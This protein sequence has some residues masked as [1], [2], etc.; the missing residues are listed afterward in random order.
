[1]DLVHTIFIVNHH[2]LGK[3]S[4][5]IVKAEVGVG[6]CS[7]R[8]IIGDVAT[9]CPGIFKDM[10]IVCSDIILSSREHTYIIN[11]WSRISESA[12]SV[13]T[14]NDLLHRHILESNPWRHLES[15]FVE[16]VSAESGNGRKLFTCVICIFSEYS[17]IGK[18]SDTAVLFEDEIRSLR[19]E[20]SYHL[21]ITVECSVQTEGEPVRII[22]DILIKEVC[23]CR[24]LSGIVCLCAESG[25]HILIIIVG[26]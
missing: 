14:D 26:H 20:P 13:C 23:K 18:I 15:L 10:V 21:I 22:Y 6:R 3:L 12:S 8:H 1:M 5:E 11:Q 2:L 25:I 9:E 7:E 17:G 24:M 4:T 16:P 19:C